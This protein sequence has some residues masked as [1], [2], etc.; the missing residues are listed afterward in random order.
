MALTPAQMAAPRHYDRCPLC[1][2]VK[3]KRSRQCNDCRFGSADLKLWPNLDR[4]GGP[5]SCWPWLGA[6]DRY[7]YGKLRLGPDLTAHRVAYRAVHGGI[8]S[9]LE[10]DHLCRNKACAN[11]AHLEAVHHQ[12][13]IL[14]GRNRQR[15][16]AHC[17]QGHPFDEA[18]T[19]LTTGRNGRPSRVCRTC[20]RDRSLTYRDRRTARW[21]KAQAAA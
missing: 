14:R 7:G 18:N 13:N 1:G 5:D 16:Q 2:G 8:P 12:V 15:E 19:R 20:A 6:L 3:G 9:D 21:A 4:S 10:L 11:P 17:G